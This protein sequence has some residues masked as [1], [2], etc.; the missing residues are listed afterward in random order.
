LLSQDTL[1]YLHK[2]FENLRGHI[3]TG[4][5]FYNSAPSNVK[6]A[7]DKFNVL[8]H[9]TEHLIRN[10][11]TPT[12]IGTFTNRPRISLN[13]SDYDL[14]T[15][16]WKYGEVYINY[17]EVGKTLLDVFKDQDEYVSENN[18]R[19]Q[20]YYSADFMIKF[21]VELTKEFYQHRVDKFNE[22]YN[23]QSYTFEKL[24]LGMIPVAILNHGEP[25]SGYTRIES[26]CIK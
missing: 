5:D 23:K 11:D 22:W 16:K 18:I 24:S 8:I 9:E 14:F 13:D 25:Y 21:G 6:Q 20:Q 3:E 2:F 1:N 15:V 19:P 4:T 26:V 12:V 17:C 10:S 7:V